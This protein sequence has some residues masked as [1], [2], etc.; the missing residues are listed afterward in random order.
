M[1]LTALG[2]SVNAL[3]SSGNS[4]RRSSSQPTASSWYTPCGATRVTAAPSTSDLPGK[5]GLARRSECP[6]RCCPRGTSPSARRGAVRRNM[7]RSACLTPGTHCRVSR[8]M[9]HVH[10]RGAVDDLGHE[11]VASTRR[12]PACRPRPLPE[13]RWASCPLA[14]AH[15]PQARDQQVGVP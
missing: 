4:I 2:H 9:V 3:S 11:S 7:R 6:C 5:E 1:P 12:R 10:D 8:R 13:S 14:S 15:K